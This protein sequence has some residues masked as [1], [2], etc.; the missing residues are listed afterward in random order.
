[1]NIGDIVP[2]TMGRLPKPSSQPFDPGRPNPPTSSFFH[3]P[4]FFPLWG[5]WF[6]LES[7]G[8]RP[9]LGFHGKPGRSLRNSGLSPILFPGGKEAGPA[10]NFFSASFSPHFFCFG[11]GECLPLASGESKMPHFEVSIFFELSFSDF[12]GWPFFGAPF[13]GRPVPWAAALAPPLRLSGRL[14]SGALRSVRSSSGAGPG[15]SIE[16][17]AP[18]GEDLFLSLSAKF[19]GPGRSCHGG[20]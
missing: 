12:A 13:G 17:G 8:A 3:C 16:V 14:S 11:G 15:S 5:P 1:M 7:R 4:V 18:R 19:R 20:R 6:N 10:S 9:K 2:S